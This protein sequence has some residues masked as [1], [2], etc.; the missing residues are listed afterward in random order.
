VPNNPEQERRVWFMNQEEDNLYTAARHL[1]STRINP[2]RA[3]CRSI[4]FGNLFKANGK[5]SANEIVETQRRAERLAA[6]RPKCGNSAYRWGGNIAALLMP[7][8]VAGLRFHAS[9]TA[10]NSASGD[11]LDRR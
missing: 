3:S 1:Q 9:G 8:T 10:G 5:R 7:A 11:K 2:E 4:P 6:L